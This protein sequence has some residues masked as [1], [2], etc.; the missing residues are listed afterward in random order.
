MALGASAHRIMRSVM[1]ETLGPVV[2]GILIGSGA[3]LATTRWVESLLFGL[4]P[5]DPLTI[6]LA[7]L[8]LLAVA[9]IAGYLPA[10][11]AARVDPMVA[12]K[13]E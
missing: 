5:Q 6:G 9:A 1:R 2:L 13:C 12:L 7:A 8:V 10:R 3:A 4:R 11:R